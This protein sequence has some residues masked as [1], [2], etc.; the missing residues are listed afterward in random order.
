MERTKSSRNINITRLALLGVNLAM[1]IF[2][3]TLVRVTTRHIADQFVA[4]PFLDTLQ[5]VPIPPLT[6]QVAAL[7]CF[8]VLLLLFAAQ[9]MLL[10]GKTTAVVLCSVAQFLLCLAIM[11]YLNFGYKGIL[12][13]PVIGIILHIRGVRPR[14]LVM[15]AVVLAYVFLDFDILSSR[16]GLNSLS[17]YVQ[18][19]TA[20]TQVYLYSI[21]NVLSSLNDVLFILFMVVALQQEMVETARLRELYAK[22]SRSAEELKV[23]NLQLEE[24][25]L[26]SERNA[27][28]RERNR[29]ARDI[30]DTLGHTLTGISTAVDACI[31]LAEKDPPRTRQQLERVS[32][33]ARNGL[34]DVRRSVRALRPDVLERFSLGT[35]LRKMV[36]EINQTT[37]IQIDLHYQPGIV[38]GDEAK[39]SI[40]RIV[41]ESVTNSVRHGGAAHIEVRLTLEDDTIHIRIQDDGAGCKNIVTGFGLAHMQER[42]GQMD[43]TIHFDGMN[44]FF[45]HVVIPNKEEPE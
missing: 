22:I 17:L 41:Q 8:G 23:M 18:F 38:A 6:A 34:L 45:T 36:E 9:S 10:A 19:Y 15:A 21:R 44:G 35:A 31:E 29:M 25:A 39:E 43:G 30:H 1:L 5:H 26:Q 12:F 3:T 24:Y 42:V 32:E 37:N 14:V 20:D 13:L 33:V 16:F 28:I 2:L 11:Y 40:Y 27:Q 4:R 7:L